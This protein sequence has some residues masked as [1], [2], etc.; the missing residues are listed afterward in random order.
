M[1]NS[2]DNWKYLSV[3]NNLRCAWVIDFNIAQLFIS[4]L[5]T[6]KLWMSS[7][8]ELLLYAIKINSRFKW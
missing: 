3:K 6:F 2:A 4:S 1:L 7:G 5:I 8:C